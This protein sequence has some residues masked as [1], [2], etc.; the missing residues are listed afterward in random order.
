[1]LDLGFPSARATSIRVFHDVSS[2]TPDADLLGVVPPYIRV[3]TVFHAVA[4]FVGSFTISE[5][6]AF[7]AI[8]G[9]TFGWATTD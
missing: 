8:T 5:Q 7:A 6:C 3:A 2:F 4:G 1:M 9:T